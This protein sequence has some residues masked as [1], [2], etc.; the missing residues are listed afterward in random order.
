MQNKDKQ[1]FFHTTWKPAKKINH[2]GGLN[3]LWKLRN[4]SEEIHLGLLSTKTGVQP[5]E[6]GVLCVRVMGAVMYRC[7][8]DLVLPSFPKHLLL[9]QEHLSLKMSNHFFCS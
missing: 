5:E 9:A 4:S 1:A 8:P 2:F 7:I 3:K 6:Q